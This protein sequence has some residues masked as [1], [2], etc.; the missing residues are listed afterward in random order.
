MIFCTRV[1]GFVNAPALIQRALVG[2]LN[3]SVDASIYEKKRD[4]LYKALCDIGYVVVK[5]G[6][7]FYFFPKSPIEDEVQFCR[8]LAEEKTLAVPGRGFGSPGYFRLSYCL[9]DLTLEGAVHGLRA[10]FERAT[11]QA[12]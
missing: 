4:F 12:S 7:A 5:P 2:S 11:Q 1:L 10:A 9:P 8:M 6:G 3:E